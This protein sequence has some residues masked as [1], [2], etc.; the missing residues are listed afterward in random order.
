MTS[1]C[2]YVM[3]VRFQLKNQTNNLKVAIFSSEGP[4]VVTLKYQLVS[5][6][7]QSSVICAA[8]CPLFS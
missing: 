8:F 5:M 1:K 6:C 4:H 3:H 2:S 7:E